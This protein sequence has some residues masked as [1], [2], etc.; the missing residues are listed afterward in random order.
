MVDTP[1]K[2]LSEHAAALT[3]EPIQIQGNSP[4]DKL[5]E[6]SCINYA[7]IYNVEHNVKVFFIGRL[8]PTSHTK[9]LL[10]VNEAWLRNTS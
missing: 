9:V 4:R 1:P 3:N 6:D 10:A 5:D 7:K 8:T 2:K